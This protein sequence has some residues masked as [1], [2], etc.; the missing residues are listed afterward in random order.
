M[1]YDSIDF[2]YIKNFLYYSI[3]FIN[4]K[5]FLKLF[6]IIL[7]YYLI[8]LYKYYIKNTIILI[9]IFYVFLMNIVIISLLIIRLFNAHNYYIKT[10]KI[11]NDLHITLINLLSFCFISFEYECDEDNN[12]NDLSQDN[13]QLISN[14]YY[15]YH[16]NRN[17]NQNYINS[18]DQYGLPNNINTDI[19]KEILTIKELLLLYITYLF[20][21]CKSMHNNNKNLNKIQY[22]DVLHFENIVN[23]KICKLY[24]NFN[25]N[26]KQFK[27]NYLEN[28]LY[29]IIHK[30]YNIGILNSYNYKY[31]LKYINIIQLNSS[32]LLYQLNKNI[33]I[34]KL[35]HYINEVLIIINIFSLSIY[36]IN[37]LPKEGI[38]Y[39][40]IISFIYL[41]INSLIY[42]LLD[43]FKYV[44]LD[45]K[46]NYGINLDN[47][48][49][50]IYD[51]FYIISNIQNIKI[52]NN[53][54]NIEILI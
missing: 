34:F 9:E 54:Y 50:N 47:I 52:D 39:V 2:E 30:V 8:W 7:F 53:N 28:E 19:K 45:Y 24:Y 17:N 33:L 26:D 13:N 35:L 4:C 40:L 48:L 5:I 49:H 23:Y 11:I 29:R 41:Y 16:N 25:I 10:N 3:N 37:Y 21:I 44:D 42:I 32:T 36:Y 38:L 20:Q 6:I 51:E 27:L 43:V 12:I 14:S 22:K 18:N 46:K 31:I 1:I 15:V